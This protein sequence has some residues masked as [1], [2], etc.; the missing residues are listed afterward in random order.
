MFL[1]LV[2]FGY[3]SYHFLYVERVFAQESNYMPPME[4][5]EKIRHAVEEALGADECFGTMS[6][7]NWRDQSKR[8]RMDISMNEGCGMTEAKRLAKRVSE[9][10]QRASSSKFEAEVSLSVLGREVWH[11]VP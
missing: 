4:E 10:V 6:S 11:Y 1:G 3:V 9:I 2:G 7:F 8:Y 5:M